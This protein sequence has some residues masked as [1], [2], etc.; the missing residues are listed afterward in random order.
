MRSTIVL[1]LLIVSAWMAPAYSSDQLDLAESAAT[2]ARVAAMEVWLQA[3]S[4]AQLQQALS[5]WQRLEQGPRE[6]LQYEL[7]VRAREMDWPALE[8]V[9][10]EWSEQS[11]QVIRERPQHRQVLQELAYPYHHAAQATLQI[12]RWRE[13]AEALQHALMAGDCARATE[14]AQQAELPL[15]WLYQAARNAPSACLGRAELTPRLRLLMSLGANSPASVL[16][17]DL[18]AVSAAQARR[19]YAV[20]AAV[21]PAQQR[22]VWASALQRAHSSLASMVDHEAAQLES[23]GVLAA[24]DYLEQRLFEGHASAWFASVRFASEQRLSELWTGTMSSG[25]A[26]QQRLLAAALVSHPRVGQQSWLRAM[27]DA[28]QLAP[29]VREYL[30]EVLQ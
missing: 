13:Q 25:D 14:T 8:A 28:P 29:G 27:A 9:L 16:Q 4:E 20:A 30:W 17:Q 15:D 1:C 19:L 7:S 21:L 10:A 2:E 3:R 12:W 11:A 6:R 18:A 26:R 5:D 22:W 23:D 24:A